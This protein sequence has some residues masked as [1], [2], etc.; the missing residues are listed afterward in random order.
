[1]EI[2][3]YALR[4][5]LRFD[6][7]G[8]L[9]TEDLFSL[10]VKDLDN[11]YKLLSKEKKEREQDSLLDTSTQDKELD[12]KIEIVKDVFTTKQNEIQDRLLEELKAKKK[13]QLIDLIDKKEN[14]GLEQKSIEEL[15]EELESL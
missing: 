1:M 7:K 8:Y 9:T 5:S 3:K 13:T 6:Y 2:Y 14:E 10:S 12:V 4:N 15:R 11:I